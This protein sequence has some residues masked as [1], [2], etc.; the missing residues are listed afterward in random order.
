MN[1]INLKKLS[2]LLIIVCLKFSVGTALAYSTTASSAGNEALAESAAGNPE[3][4]VSQR[5]RGVELQAARK[6]WTKERMLNAK[7]LPL[8]ALDETRIG[9]QE[10]LADYEY[11]P[12]EV[13]PGGLPEA[14][15]LS[16]EL[17]SGNF[18]DSQL[19]AMYS[20]P[21]T[22]ALQSPLGYFYPAPFTRYNV[23]QKYNM[24]KHYP[25][26][27]IGK[28]FFQKPNSSTTWVC[29]GAVAVG[30]AVWTAGHCVYTPGQGWNR[31]MTFVPAY[32]AGTRP[33]GTWTVKSKAALNGWTNNGNF[34][35][36]IGMVS[37]FDKSGVTIGS[38]VGWLG[39]MFNAGPKQHFHGIGYPANINSARYSVLCAASTARRD[40]EPGPDPLGIGCDMGAGISGGP[41]IVKYAPYTTGAAN[42]VNGFFS[43]YYTDTPKEVFSPYFGNGAKN[44]YN[45]GQGQ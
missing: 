22:E 8:P 31:N 17:L 4:V 29:S 21:A 20:G 36:D 14:N 39:A 18:V 45:W 15:R 9:T 40:A 7:E 34:A 3:Q 37:V 12:F 25:W 2:T 32:R 44:L 24:W 23:N 10:Q 38:R 41:W 35:Y 28:L 43:Y 13:V 1:H 5:V 19:D 11:G 33:Y 30:R 6:F 26:K 16:Q 27:T 42:Y